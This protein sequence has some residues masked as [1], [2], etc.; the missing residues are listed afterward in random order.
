MM[1]P[2]LIREMS[3]EAAELA[4]MENRTPFVVWPEDLDDPRRVKIPSIGSYLPNGWRRVN[5]AEEI[6][7]KIDWKLDAGAA[8]EGFGSYLVD[9]TGLGL[10][11]EPAY[12]EMQFLAELRPGYGYAIIEEGQFQYCVGV[13]QRL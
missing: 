2:E 12:T 11:T 8:N 4:A 5:I 13:F 9:A 10:A 7:P 6:P 3:R 1:S